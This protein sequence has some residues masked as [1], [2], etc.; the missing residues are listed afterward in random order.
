MCQKVSVLVF[1]KTGTLTL[2]KP[3]VENFQ[4]FSPKIEKD[5]FLLLVGSCESNSE[6]SIAQEICN[7]CKKEGKKKQWKFPSKFEATPG[8]GVRCQVE[9]HHVVIGNKLWMEENGMCKM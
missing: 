6:H 4:L 2:G 5:E 8:K 9:E 1:D 7:F 3:Q